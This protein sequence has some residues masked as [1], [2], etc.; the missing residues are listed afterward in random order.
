MR[1]ELKGNRPSIWL[2]LFLLAISIHSAFFASWFPDPLGWLF[3]L[4]AFIAAFGT[5]YHAYLFLSGK[6]VR[7]VETGERYLVLEY[8]NGKRAEYK[9]QDIVTLIFLPSPSTFGR[10]TLML[11][12]FYRVRAGPYET[13]KYISFKVPDE[14]TAKAIIKEIGSHAV[15]LDP[16]VGKNLS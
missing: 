7:T 16:S 14:K 3:Y 5:C 10:R 13:S 8:H 4:G 9:Y 2:I 11:S 1:F 12:F 6:S 15:P